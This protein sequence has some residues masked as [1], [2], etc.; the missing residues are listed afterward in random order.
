MGITVEVHN[1]GPL[2]SA[3][4]EL[5]DLNVLVG[6]NNTGKTFF[7]TVLHRVLAS[8]HAYALPRRN[9][10][11][12]VPKQF[13]KMVEHIIRVFGDKSAALQTSKWELSAANKEWIDAVNTDMLT[14]FGSAVRNALA[15]AYST[16]AAG[17]RRR[18]ISRFAPDAHVRVSYASPESDVSWSVR[19]QF[20]S[21]RIEV[22]PPTSG[23]WLARIL[24]A[25][26]VEF[27]TGYWPLERKH[28]DAALADLE[29]TCWR[30]AF[31]EG[32]AALFDDW[33][34]DAVHL[35]SERSGIVQNYRLLSSAAARSLASADDRRGGEALLS[36]TQADLLSLL[37]S[38]KQGGRDAGA[39]AKF[40]QF[41]H[42]F[43]EDLGAGIDLEDH[44]EPVRS[45]V[46]ATT[47]GRF[48][49]SRA[50]AMLSELAALH[51][52]L[53]FHLEPGDS[54]TIDEP[55][56]HLHPA[57]QRR[58][59]SFLVQL[60]LGHAT[61]ILTTHS[62]FFV[63]QLNNHIRAS[64]LTR[65]QTPPSG[66]TSPAID[67]S[68]VRAMRFRRSSRWCTGQAIDIDPVDGIDEATFTDE[69]DAL[70]SESTKTTNPLLD[71]AID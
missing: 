53:R 54:L 70:Y 68:R 42:E 17:L 49:I 5:A 45:I 57:A 32:R 39:S 58:M 25:E 48:P 30:L 55:E 35:P 59:A 31:A 52:A 19:I 38:A 34:R 3:E 9:A 12:A 16:E 20:D 6:D 7:A 67:R 15:Y 62:D 41:V 10:V 24:N 51:L 13:R 29:N 37:L 47:E 56:A 11:G 44:D 66:T 36:G 63:G 1:L 26:N 4:L 65:L 43:E 46:A 8:S 18:T 40:A 27:A 21:E 2:K 22:S 60:V 69:M 71:T 61:V 23:H 50:S 64:E 14:G 33:P 28:T